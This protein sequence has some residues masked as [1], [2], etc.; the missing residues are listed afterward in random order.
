MEIRGIVY[1]ERDGVWFPINEACSSRLN[2]WITLNQ[3]TQEF[4]EFFEKIEDIFTQ[5]APAYSEK[6]KSFAY[7]I[8]EY[9]EKWN[10]LSWKQF[11]SII[12]MC[13]TYQAFLEGKQSGYYSYGSIVACKTQGLSF[14]T[15]KSLVNFSKLENTDRYMDNLYKQIFGHK[16]M[17]YEEAE[18]GY[19]VDY[20]KDG[21]R[22]FLL[23][24]DEDVE[25]ELY[26]SFGAI[27]KFIEF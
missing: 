23:P 5:D 2:S 17:F 3:I 1:E 10:W 9:L 4:P 27:T 22:V 7:S 20:D 15:K 11:D 18:E 21:K 24:T 6:A 16:P 19:T 25:R 12:C 8:M 26:N 13:D 14:V